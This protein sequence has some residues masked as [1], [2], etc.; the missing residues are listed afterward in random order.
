[1]SNA[2]YIEVNSTYRD[3]NLW[4]L[5]SEFEIPISQ[6]G[7]KSMYDAIDPVSLSEPI[8]SWTGNN[9]IVNST[10]ALEAQIIDPTVDNIGYESDGTT[11]VIKTI[12]PIQQL[13]NYYDGLIIQDLGVTLPS[14]TGPLRRI[15]NSHY[16][17]FDGTYY[18]MQITVFNS[19]M[20]TFT[21]Y[22]NMIIRDPTDFTDVNNPLIFVPNGAFQENAYNSYILY[23]ETINQSRPIIKYDNITNILT[24][25]TSG[26]TTN[27]SGP[28]TSDWN[29]NDNFSL[30]KLKPTIA[31]MG[32]INYP[33]VVLSTTN[34]TITVNDPTNLLKSKK[35]YY[36]NQFL[37]I[38]PYNGVSNYN[39]NYNPTPTNNESRKITSYSY[40]SNVATFIVSPGFS[41]MPI[42]N[43]PIEILP[44][45]YDNFNPFIYTGSLVS[46]QD[47]I[48]YE[49]Q[50]IS[51]TM[52]NYILSVATGGR[53]AFYPYVY[54]QLSNVTAS[55]SK[56]KNIIYSNNPNATNVIFRAPIYDVQDPL[57][58]PYVRINGG[59][60]VQTV[61]FKPN[62]NLYFKITLP[63]GETFNTTLPEFFSPAAPN[64]R[65]QIT[66]VFSIKRI[67]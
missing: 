40:S 15:V 18:R 19:F 3:R 47:M 14:T 66:A 28:I 37:R 56:L 5:A 55:G 65:S 24:L 32:T 30:R 62:D 12:Q 44:F 67:S 26:T 48:C 10:S 1:M 45:S 41:T 22:D 50:L 7:K 52:P 13:R 42:A 49:I 57:N 36:K 63:N 53:I 51:L 23:N 20:D 6:T 38:L 16:M 17:G 25:D 46:Q 27:F 43:S 59:G 2:R 11:F 34:T 61:K 31:D 9:L 54:V 29:T 4:P 33:L 8:F 35:N 21:Y 60:M 39:Y 64:P 58:T